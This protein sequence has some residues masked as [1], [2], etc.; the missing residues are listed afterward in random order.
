MCAVCCTLAPSAVKSLHVNETLTNLMSF[1]WS[2]PTGYFDGFHIYAIASSDAA[3][4]CTDTVH[5]KNFA[6]STNGAV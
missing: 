2:R 5:G 6:L 1:S 4:N 3:I